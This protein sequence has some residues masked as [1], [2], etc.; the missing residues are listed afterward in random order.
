[1]GDSFEL[2]NSFIEESNPNFQQL[3][4]CSHDNVENF[5]GIFICTDCGNE[6][7]DWFD[8]E[9]ECKFIKT[10]D[11][12][13]RQIRRV[14]DKSIFKDLEPFDI[15]HNIQLVSNTLYNEVSKGR[16]FRGL[17]R[18]A[19]I[20]V[21]VFLAYK[22]T[23]YPQSIERLQNL[24]GISKKTVSKGIKIVG[25]TLDDQTKLFLSV[26]DLIP[27]M[28]K[29]FDSSE[30]VLNHVLNLYSLIKNKSSTINRSRPRSIVA[31]LIYFYMKHTE[32][33]FS[34]KMFCSNVGLS[35]LTI[36]KLYFEIK[37]CL[38]NNVSINNT[39]YSS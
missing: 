31:A 24:F 26:E 32:K 13:G 1:M 2:F 25:M 12:F 39:T 17:S 14:Y 11:G 15:P 22:Q 37:K 36:T 4:H 28:L 20:V 3:I 10:T 21:V 33:E 30:D 19:V 8:T 16:I 6:F 35:K 5:R 18:K 38:E 9:K 29:K 27:E 23:S 34:D 7:Q